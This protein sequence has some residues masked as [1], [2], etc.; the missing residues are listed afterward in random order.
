MCIETFTEVDFD[1]EHE[2]V[3]EVE[4]ETTPHRKAKGRQATAFVPKAPS[5]VA[6]LPSMREITTD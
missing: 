5:N 6:R 3:E 1:Q 4:V 2:E